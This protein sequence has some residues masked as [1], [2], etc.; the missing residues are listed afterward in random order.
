[1]DINVGNVVSLK[2]KKCYPVKWDENSMI[3]RIE[4][5]SGSLLQVGENVT[6]P[7]DAVLYA[8][9]FIDSYPAL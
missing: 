5:E 6:N 9:T 1:M 8:Q 7:E 4:K 3:V 2:T